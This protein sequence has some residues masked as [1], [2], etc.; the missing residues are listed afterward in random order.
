MDPN[1]RV[2][3]LQPTADYFIS[4]EEGEMKQREEKKPTTQIHVYQRGQASS[5][6]QA[7]EETAV[8]VSRDA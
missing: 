1:L 2:H 4:S 6:L 7:R 3:Q 8:I 5:T